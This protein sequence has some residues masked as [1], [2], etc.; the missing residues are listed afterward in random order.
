MSMKDYFYDNL[1]ESIKRFTNKCIEEFQ[2][3]EKQIEYVNSFYK[4]END[5]D[6]CE[7]EGGKFKGCKGHKGTLGDYQ[8]D[9]ALLKVCSAVYTV[10]FCPWCGADI[11]KPEPRIIIK[12]S[13]ETFVALVNGTDWL[14]VDPEEG[15]D[16]EIH[17]FDISVSLR[18]NLISEIERNG[19]ADEIAKLRPMVKDGDSLET[20]LAVYEGTF[21]T[22]EDRTS[23]MTYRLATVSDLED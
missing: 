2:A 21:V 6:K 13:G 11:R 9:D 3:H 14:C 19:L 16:Y 15:K 5:M 10:Q 23:D 8:I 18:W 22:D 4:K 17:P 20:L 7:W 12:K 1:K